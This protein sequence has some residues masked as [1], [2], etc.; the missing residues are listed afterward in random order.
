MGAL[1]GNIWA[2]G[3]KPTLHLAHQSNPL[4]EGCAFEIMALRIPGIG[5]HRMLWRTA[6]QFEQTMVC[7]IYPPDYSGPGYYVFKFLGYP[8]EIA[9]G[10]K[11]LAEEIDKVKAIF[12]TKI[13]V[14][15]LRQAVFPIPK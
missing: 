7:T 15:E 9:A 10:R 13:A 2:T 1:D 14:V 11:T 6:R 12:K 5:Q 8:Q 3:K 4:P